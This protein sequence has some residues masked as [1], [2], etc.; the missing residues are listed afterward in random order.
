VPRN[1]LRG[2]AEGFRPGTTDT[3][4]RKR[5]GNTPQASR[6]NHTVDGIRL[7]VLKQLDSNENAPRLL[8]TFASTEESGIKALLYRKTRAMVK[9][10][11]SLLQESSSKNALQNVNRGR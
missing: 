7:A 1:L 9:T 2:F 3:E 5:I 10:Q 4:I 11:A 8:D 6:E